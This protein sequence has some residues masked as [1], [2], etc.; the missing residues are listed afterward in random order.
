MNINLIRLI[1]KKDEVLRSED[2]LLLEDLAEQLIEEDIVLMEGAKDSPV[3]VILVESDDI[4]EIVK[5]SLKGLN[6]YIYLITFSKGRSYAETLSLYSYLSKQKYSVL[7]DDDPLHALKGILPT[8]I[9]ISRVKS[10]IKGKN[11]GMFIPDDDSL[12]SPKYDIGRLNKV[13]GI[14][15][16]RIGKD[17]L[18]KEYRKNKIG[19]PPHLLKM[20]KMVRNS[21]ALNHSLYLYNAIKTLAEK[22]HLVGL[23]INDNTINKDLN[24]SSDLALS[25]LNEE[26]IIS[27]K[28]NDL[29]SLLTSYL[30]FSLNGRMPYI[31]SPISSNYDEK[32]LFI[33]CD[34]P[35]LNQVKS[36]E[37]IN[38]RDN[39]LKV[40]SEINLGEGSLLKIGSDFIHFYTVSVE[41]KESIDDNVCLYVDEVPLFTFI[42][43][44]AEKQ[45]V[46]TNQDISVQYSA[47]L[48]YLEIN[49]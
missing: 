18:Y 8:F 33:K 38:P 16:V 23:T 45:M 25:L 6:K 48:N 41:I 37:I 44:A 12:L 40:K 47:L 24:I 32:Q 29:S 17:E 36:F 10:S 3:D 11:F 19:N 1:D 21:L 20:K 43:D 14:N 9:D 7:L 49:K 22:Y 5:K 39:I 28:N 15:I 27:V 2:D 46:L 4:S 13:L 31:I 26:G 34:Y 35:P 42:R 30:A